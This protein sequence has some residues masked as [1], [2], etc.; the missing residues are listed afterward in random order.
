MANKNSQDLDVEDVDLEEIPPAGV[1]VIG[2]FLILASINVSLGGPVVNLVVGLAGLVLILAFIVKMYLLYQESGLNRAF[3]YAITAPADRQKDYSVD[4]L[5][6]SEGIEQT[7]KGITLEH[8]RN[9]PYQE[10]EEYVAK[11][12]SEKGY[13]TTIPD[14]SGGDGGIDVIAKRSEMKNTEK[15]LI[16]AK[17]YDEGKKI[18]APKL[19]EYSALRLDN[20]VDK[21]YV[22][23]TSEFT[24]DALELAEDKNVKTLNGKEFLDEY[25]KYVES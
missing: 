21:V 22:V 4:I 10:F 14:D 12:W 19:R 1:P 8:M 25:Q 11:V 3:D 15:V 24:K 23:T 17:R 18:T 5:E 13:Q 2:I 20:D 7:E 9:V 16:Q 6:S